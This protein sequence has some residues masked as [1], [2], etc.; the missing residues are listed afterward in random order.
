MGDALEERDLERRRACVDCED[1]GHWYLLS[2][3]ALVVY[4]PVL[5]VTNVAVD[6]V[7]EQLQ[8]RYRKPVTLSNGL[9]HSRKDRDT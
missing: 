5:K 9:R 7:R 3:E 6:E 8:I 2:P 1:K 4:K